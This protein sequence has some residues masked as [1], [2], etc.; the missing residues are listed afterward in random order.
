MPSY[1][2]FFYPLEVVSRYCNQ[3]LQGSKVNTY[4]YTI[5]IQAYDTYLS[6]PF[7]GFKDK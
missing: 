4:I 1:V 3:Q 5:R 6:L 2:N 7:S